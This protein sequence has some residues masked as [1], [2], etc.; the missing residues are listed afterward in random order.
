MDEA[1]G[2]GRLPHRHRE[3]GTALTAGLDWNIILRIVTSWHDR[4]VAAVR[5]PTRLERQTA[6]EEVER[7]LKKEAAEAISWK[8]AVPS[9]VNRREA[10]SR[11][12]GT[13]IAGLMM[14]G[15]GVASTVE[16]SERCSSHLT[17]LA[18]A[19]A[20]YHAEHGRY[21]AKLATLVPRHVKEVP[22]DIFNNNAELHYKR[23]G[24]GYLL[25]SVGPNGKDDGGRGTQD[26]KKN[27][28][29]DD[30]AVRMPASASP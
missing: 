24:D 29:W 7:E 26:C 5:K 9:I 19:L 30:L 15:E 8:A 11:R 18:F 4:L 3:S 17:K 13:I 1:A 10:V 21:P 27:D 12:V 20:Q 16:D 14:P 23:E 25:Y 28:N 6:I 22:K 2:R